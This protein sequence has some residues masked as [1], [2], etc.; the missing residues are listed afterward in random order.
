MSV[1]QLATPP[2]G[3]VI[4]SLVGQCSLHHRPRQS[5]HLL[6]S[7]HYCMK[8]IWSCKMFLRSMHCRIEVTNSKL[9][10]QF[11][12]LDREIRSMQ[13]SQQQHQNDRQSRES[14]RT[15]SQ[16]RSRSRSRSAERKASNN[17]ASQLQTRAARHILDQDTEAVNAI[18]QLFQESIE[19]VSALGPYCMF[20]H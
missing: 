20:T 4:G 7:C 3:V 9:L 2:I 12:D 8:G 15:K 13:L 11:E 10:K 17:E 14:K 5:L 19:Q 6:P 1:A 18:R 16:S